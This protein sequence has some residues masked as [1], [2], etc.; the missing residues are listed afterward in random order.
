MSPLIQGLN[1]RSACDGTCRPILYFVVFRSTGSNLQVHR[2][3]L[4]GVIFVNVL[5]IEI[6]T[7][8]TTACDQEKGTWNG[9]ENRR[10]ED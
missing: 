1:Y 10:G 5:E 4:L 3:C 7:L 2:Q 6:V 9:R 8:P